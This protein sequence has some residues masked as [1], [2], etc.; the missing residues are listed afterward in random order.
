MKERHIRIAGGIIAGGTSSRMKAGRVTRDKFLER[1]DRV[2]IIEM[3]ARRI[4]AQ[5]D[6]LFI[7]ANG[8]PE[9]LTSL[10]LPIITDIDCRHRGPLAGLLTA[11]SY[12]HE[13]DF[14]LTA[15]A[16][17]PFVPLDLYQKLSEQQQKNNAEI[18]LARSQKRIHP[19]FG[20]WNTS[21]KTRLRDWLQTSERASV[22][23]FAEHI[24][25]ELVDF[26]QSWVP[27]LESSYD[28]FFNINYPDD[29]I[30]ARRIN[31]ALK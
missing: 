17:S 8:D 13:Y 6:M 31:K 10:G 22:L 9:R 12:V 23:S 16:D 3:I 14:L 21:L 2:S 25:F 19:V 24:G 5:V 7:N 1:L 4:A 18:V 11:L 27:A 28:P 20:L 26:P 29:L 15:P 30:E